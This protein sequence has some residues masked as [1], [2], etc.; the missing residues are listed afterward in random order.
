MLE[1]MNILR[2]PSILT[3]TTEGLGNSNVMRDLTPIQ[4]GNRVR[5]CDS[6]SLYE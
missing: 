4:L 2:L 6:Y 3:N 5:E 1:G